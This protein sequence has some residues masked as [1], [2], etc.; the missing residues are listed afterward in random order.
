MTT[1]DAGT[2]GF[3]AGTPVIFNETVHGPVIGYATV[4]GER[5]ALSSARS[6]R[7]REVVSAFGFAR[8]ERRHGP[9]RRQLLRRREQ[10]RVHVQL[11]LRGQGRRRDVLGRPASRTATRRST[12]GLPTKGTGKYEWRGL[13]CARTSTRTAR[14]PD[15]RHDRQLEQQAGAGLAGGGRHLGLRLGDPQRAA[16]GGHERRADP[17]AGVDGRRR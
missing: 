14:R 2:V 1:F 16:R 11:V 15:G 4:D 12:S 8:P 17:H 9:R 13:H 7:N 6:T 10:D 5:V 3:G